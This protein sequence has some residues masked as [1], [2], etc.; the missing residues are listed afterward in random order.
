MSDHKHTM[1]ETEAAEYC[2]VSV[3]FLRRCRVN[4]KSR[5]GTAGP[6][7][8]KIGRLVRYRRAD[9]DAWLESLSRP[10]T[11]AA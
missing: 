2:A 11:P 4:G 8:I 1:T 9:L 10:H 6:T 5:L 7:T 3:P